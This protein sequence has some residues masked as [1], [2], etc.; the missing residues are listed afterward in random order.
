MTDKINQKSLALTLGI[1]FAL[2]HTV[3][4]VLILAGAI[5]WILK[6]HFFEPKFSLLPFSLPMLLLGIVLTFIFGLIVGWLI[7]V[8]YNAF[9]K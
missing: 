4:V 8:I 7:A 9:H 3:G 6:M 2:G 5:N 1:V